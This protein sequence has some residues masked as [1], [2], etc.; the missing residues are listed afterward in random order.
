MLFEYLRPE[1]LCK[2]IF[3]R[4]SRGPPFFGH[5]LRFCDI[6]KW[7]CTTFMCYLRDIHGERLSS[8][9]FQMLDILKEYISQKQAMR[10]S[11][12]GNWGNFQNRRLSIGYLRST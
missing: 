10:D 1:R 6:I 3:R 12:G 8:L 9:W 11:D 2:K 4:H 5:R 7:H